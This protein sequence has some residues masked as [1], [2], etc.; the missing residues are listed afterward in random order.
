M[1]AIRSYY[2][3]PQDVP[4]HLKPVQKVNETTEDL[5]ASE[6]FEETEEEFTADDDEADFDDDPPMA[7]GE[8]DEET[9]E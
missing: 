2:E 5:L 4:P 6:Q 3:Q 8:I 7:D 9:N 1:Y